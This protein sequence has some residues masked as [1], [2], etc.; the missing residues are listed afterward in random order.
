[1]ELRKTV[2]NPEDFA[3]MAEKGKRSKAELTS[4]AEEWRGSAFLTGA[5]KGLNWP[6]ERLTAR[7]AG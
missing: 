3:S 7:P 5:G 1:M 6:L 4:A 2:L